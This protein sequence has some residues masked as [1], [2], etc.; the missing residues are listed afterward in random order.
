MASA[1]FKVFC[2]GFGDRNTSAGLA[3]FT[4]MSLFEDSAALVS[5][6]K[7]ACYGK[8]GDMFLGF[9]Y[10]I[11]RAAM[12]FRRE[13]LGSH[14]SSRCLCVFSAHLDVW[15]EVDVVEKE[16]MNG[17]VFKTPGTDFP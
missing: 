5:F 4:I 17:V 15:F 13:R 3:C 12:A 9:Y 6:V 7:A 8:L 11:V 2:L 14:H 10:F 1:Y 16:D